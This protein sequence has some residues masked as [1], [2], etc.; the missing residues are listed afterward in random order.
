VTLQLF[1]WFLLVDTVGWLIGLLITTPRPESGSGSVLALVLVREPIVALVLAV[2]FL[3]LS[4]VSPRAPRVDPY[5]WYVAGIAA[6]YVLNFVVLTIIAGR[7]F[8][9]PLVWVGIHSDFQ[10]FIF[11]AGPYLLAFFVTSTLF[12]GSRL[13]TRHR[14]SG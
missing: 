10:T 3:L 5:V 1:L 8:F 9:D 2:V 7:P 6:G 12:W 14:L 4:F 11:V 13:R